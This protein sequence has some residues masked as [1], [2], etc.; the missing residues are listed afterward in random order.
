MDEIEKI[1]QLRKDYAYKLYDFYNQISPKLPPMSKEIIVSIEQSIIEE[2]EYWQKWQNR[3][4]KLN[5]FNQEIDSVNEKN[6]THN[7]SQSKLM[8][9]VYLRNSFQQQS[10]DC[11]KHYQIILSKVK[12]TRNL[13]INEIAYPLLKYASKYPAVATL[14]ESVNNTHFTLKSYCDNWK[15]S[16]IENLQNIVDH[17]YEIEILCQSIARELE[18]FDP[19]VNEEDKI[20][21]FD[22]LKSLFFADQ[23]GKLSDLIEAFLAKYNIFELLNKMKNEEYHTFKTEFSQLFS[24]KNLGSIRNNIKIINNIISTQKKINIIYQSFKKLENILK[25]E[26][27]KLHEK[28][29]KLILLCTTSTELSKL[30]TEKWIVSHYPQ[31]FSTIDKII[32]EKQK[33]FDK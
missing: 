33:L 14:Q 20:Q 6:N 27:D 18:Q 7:I 30:T 26:V 31:F 25:P 4:E 11:K 15:I 19:E 8:E 9:I 16:Q 10:D 5:R 3:L 32:I 17:I 12:Q 22:K 13:A 24:Q 1:I 21:F 28:K 29:N 2:N 23:C